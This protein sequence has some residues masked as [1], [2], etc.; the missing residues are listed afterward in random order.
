MIHKNTIENFRLL[1]RHFCRA[2]YLPYHCHKNDQTHPF[3]DAYSTARHFIT[4][5]FIV[6]KCFKPNLPHFQEEYCS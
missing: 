3:N 4:R 5:Q 1:V 6:D 2:K